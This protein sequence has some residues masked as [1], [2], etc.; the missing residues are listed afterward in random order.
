MSIILLI[1]SLI[2]ANYWRNA[3]RG[4]RRNLDLIFS[5]F[6]FL[7]GCYYTVKYV[8]SGPYL[9]LESVWFSTV[10]YVYSQSTKHISENSP[11]WVKYHFAFHIILTIGIAV[12]LDSIRLQMNIDNKSI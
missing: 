11:N 2:S 10:F 3:R 8:K 6:T 12:L 4:W 7:T 1:T 9:I 5:K